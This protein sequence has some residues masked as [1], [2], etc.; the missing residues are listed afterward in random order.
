MCCSFSDF[1][2]TVRNRGTEGSNDVHCFSSGFIAKIVATFSRR[3]GWALKLENN[4]LVRLLFTVFT[5]YNG[6]QCLT[7]TAPARI[8]NCHIAGLGTPDSREKEPVRRDYSH[9]RLNAPSPCM[10]MRCTRTTASHP[11]KSN[12]VLHNNNHSSLG[13]E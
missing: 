9:R 4:D 11:S 1:K 6:V 2:V 7:Y 13:T 12:Q 10:R 8:V 5:V 3:S